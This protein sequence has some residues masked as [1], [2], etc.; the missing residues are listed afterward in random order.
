[1]TISLPVP[2]AV[3]LHNSHSCEKK[4]AQFSIFQKYFKSR[5][6]LPETG[7]TGRGTVFAHSLK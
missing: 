6:K 2:I 3:G 1:M 4:Q 7:R 5:E